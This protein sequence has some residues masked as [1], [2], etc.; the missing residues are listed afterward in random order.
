MSPALSALVGAFRAEA[1]TLSRA[2][3]FVALTVIQAVTFLFLVT[4]FGLTGSRAPTALVL[5]DHGPAARVFV[6]RLAA[7]H[8]SFALRPMDE[9]SAQA[10]LRHG[11]LAAVI[12]IPAGFSQTIASGGTATVQVAIDNV[13]TDMTD[14]IQRALPSAIDAFGTEHRFPGIRLHVAETDLLRH[15]TGF[16]PYLVVSGLV[17]DAFVISGILGGV[18]TARE[19]E[20]GMVRLLAVAPV[21]AIFPL[22]GRALAAMAVSALAL[23][24]PAALVIFGYGIPPQHPWEMAAGLVLSLA[25]FSGFGAAAGAVLKRTMPT[26]TLIFG[27][28]LPLYIGSGALEPQR[29]DGYGTWVLAHFSPVYSA[30][31]IEEQAFHGLQVTPESTTLNFVTLCCWTLALVVMAGVALRRQAGKR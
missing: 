10:R 24:V 8:H 5:H 31:G 3:L 1:L 6:K 20:S 14:D 9:K 21:S 28:S 13:N 19:F 26:V 4:L 23:I 29:F 16:I 2:R 12:T 27:L 17:L 7:A 25:A 22:A 11:D 30:I 18:T 15:D